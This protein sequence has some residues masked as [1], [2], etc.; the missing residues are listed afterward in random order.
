MALNVKWTLD[1]KEHGSRVGTDD[2]ALA[3]RTIEQTIPGAKV[4]SCEPEVTGDL[5]IVS[6]KESFADVRRWKDA[7]DRK[8]KQAK[9]AEKPGV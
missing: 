9:D 6:V 8:E 3:T 5:G 1:G 2:V 4:L 7:E